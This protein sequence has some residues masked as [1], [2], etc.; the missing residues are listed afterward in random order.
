MRLRTTK[1]RIVCNIHSGTSSFLRSSKYLQSIFLKYMKTLRNI[2]Y[3]E[4]VTT[5]KSTAGAP[6]ECQKKGGALSTKWP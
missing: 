2:V 1:H 5:R 4:K 3:M 6:H